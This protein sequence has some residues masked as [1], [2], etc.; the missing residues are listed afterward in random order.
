MFKAL[1]NI[2]IN[3]IASVIQII[4]WPINQIIVNVMPDISDKIL[5][6][7]NTLN[8]V[9]DAITWGLGLLPSF[10]VETLL[11]IVTIEIAKHTIFTSTH[12]LIKVW[13]VFQKIKFW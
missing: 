4:V 12:M 7:T 1:F 10:L 11:F 3:M 9:F 8:T 13:N 6:V 5:V 2:I